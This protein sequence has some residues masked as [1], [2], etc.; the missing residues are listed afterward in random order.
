VSTVGQTPFF[1]LVASKHRDALFAH[2]AAH[3]ILTRPFAAQ[4]R[5]LRFGLLGEEAGW[6]RLS[7]ALTSWRAA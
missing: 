6:A 5:W 2:L 7:Q 4:P 3:G 1:T